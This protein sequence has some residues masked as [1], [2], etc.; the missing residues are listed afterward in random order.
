[1]QMVKNV[2][3]YRDKTLA[4]KL[5]ELFLTWYVESVLEKDRIL[6]IYLNAIEYGPGLYGIRPAS[7]QYFGKEPRDLNPVEAAFFSSILPAPK[8]RYK[9]FCK[10]KLTGWSVSKIARIIELMHKRGR[11]T[12]EELLAAQTTPL[13]FQPDK[14]GFCERKIPEWGINDKPGPQGRGARS[15]PSGGAP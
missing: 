8:R 15:T 3:L 6:E 11:I 1:M 4:R 5:Q 10:D 7:R 14:R 13:V 12:D 2:L 9:Q